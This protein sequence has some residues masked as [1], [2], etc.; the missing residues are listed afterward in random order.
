MASYE[1][2][3]TNL[4]KVNSGVHIFSEILYHL[5]AQNTN[6]QTVNPNYKTGC[7]SRFT[8]LALI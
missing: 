2:L 4:S 1:R 6:A 3:P 5:G 8:T 7:R